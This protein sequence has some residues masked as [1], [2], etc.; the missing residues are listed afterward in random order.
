MDHAALRAELERLIDAGDTGALKKFA[1]D[2]FTEFPENVQGQLLMGFLQ[3]TLDGAELQKEGI[4]AIQ[5]L[6]ALNAETLESEQ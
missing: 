6:E 5:K 4:D 2:H 1:T 3:E